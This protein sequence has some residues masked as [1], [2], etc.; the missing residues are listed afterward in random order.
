MVNNTRPVLTALPPGCALAPIH[1][2]DESTP[3]RIG[4]LLREVADPIGG[5]FVLLREISG[6]R[7]YLG[8]ICDQ[9]TQIQEWI[10]VWVQSGDVPDLTFSNHQEQL[11]NPT[12]D[13]RWRLDFEL[14]LTIIPGETIRT[15]METENPGPMLIKKSATPGGLALTEATPWRVCK[16]DALLDSLGLPLYSQSSHRYLHDPTATSPQKLIAATPE[17]PIN[18]DAQSSAALTAAPGLWAVFNPHGGF[19]RVQRFHPLT[20]EDLLLILE[21]QS[22]NGFTQ[23]G[24]R[25]VPEKIYADLQ[26][27]S[28]NPRGLPFL[29]HGVRDSPDR[30]NEVLFLKLAAWRDMFVAVR[31]YIKTH[32]LPLLNLSPASFAIKLHDVGDHFPALWTLKT[33]LTKP[34]QAYPLQIKSTD[35]KYFVRLGKITPSP[36]LAE[37]VAAHSFGLGSIRIRNVLPEA[38][39]IVL[40]GTL[41][42]EDFLGLNP[43]DLLWFKLPLASEKLDFYA[44]VFTGEAIGPKEARFRTIPAKLSEATLASLKQI[45][46]T[47]FPRAPYEVWPLLS[48]PCDLF[49]LGVIGVR[50]LLVHSQSNLPVI[51]DEIV[52]QSRHLGKSAEGDLI[53]ALQAMLEQEPA[54][55]ELIQPPGSAT[56]P[57]AAKANQQLWLEAL[58]IIIRLFPGTGPHSYCQ[59]FGDVSPLALESIFAKPIEQLETLL[60]RLRSLVAPR[61]TS[62]AEIARVIL[63]QLN[64]ET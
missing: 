10:E 20:L 63:D 39:G 31:N 55:R 47:A 38:G 23:G 12:L 57:P 19:V 50:L 17:A 33:L 27:W 3:L 18:S 59:D 9:Q 51:L 41:V 62:D 37:G 16:N 25:I 49:S 46:G 15:G 43:H 5:F 13:Q 24:L 32:Q 7:V 4:V 36:F 52:S 44:H 11:T 21:G 26:S 54:L 48:S 40:E 22:W 34:G 29:L 6:A 61:P 8:A 30:A 53:S 64:R 42:A 35:Q 28:T 56:S 1:Q 60:M 2:A 45:A 14:N 58:A